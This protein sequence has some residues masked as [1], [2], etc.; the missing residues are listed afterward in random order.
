[1]STLAVVGAM[2]GAAQAVAMASWSPLALFAASEQGVWYD[3][4]DFS[5]MFQD[6]AGTIPVT[7]TGQSVGKILDKSGN[8]NH[9]TQATSGKRPVLQVDGSGKYYLDFDGSLSALSTSAIDISGTDKATVW[10]GL[11]KDSDAA[12]GVAVEF[13]TNSNSVAGSFAFLAPSGAA[14]DYAAI[15]RGSATTGYLIPSFAAASAN[16]L[17]C[18][19]A[20]SGAAR[21][22]EV[23]PR[24]DG[25]IPALTTTGTANAGTGNLG[26]LALYLGGRAGTGTYF[27]GRIYGLII[28]SGASSSDDML[29]AEAYLN[30]K[31]GVHGAYFLTPTQFTDS[32]TT[33]QR[34]EYIETSPFA[35]VDFT[36]TATQIGVTFTNDIRTEFTALTEIGI[37]VNGAYSTYLTHTTEGSVERWATLSAGSKTVSIVNGPQSKPVSGNPPIGTFVQGITANAEM[38]QTNLIPTNR[39]LVYGDS[40]SIGAFATR[41]T[42]DAWD[43][44]VRAAS[45]PDSV[46]VEGWGYRS[47]YDD[48]NTSGLRA[49]FVATMAAYAPAKIWLAIGTNDYG[50]D[51]WSAASFGTAY[52]AL[53]DDLHAALPSATIYCQTPI[54]RTT[55]TANGLGST[56]GDYRTQ[57]G[58]AQSTR[59]AYATL[60]DGT[61]FMTTASLGDG[62]HPTTAGHLLYSN[63][64]RAVLGI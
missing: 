43:L 9:A 46:A 24:A 63:S 42:Q 45:Y 34:T 33:A 11:R 15:L 10:C 23:F 58:T 51:K 32:G 7:T 29:N 56:L 6:D 12:A 36:T 52:A 27:N 47:L 37:W 61:A 20:I 39:L 25:C 2:V 54:L 19:F 22:T 50:L 3:P 41:P 14:S 26:N 21:S 57:I 30:A 49:A 59:S 64:V 53:L 17:A 38:T 60:V 13:G 40:I 18:S 8:N 31:S 5:T 16:V 48:A 35:S 62:V 1:M 4:S 44:L 28:R 55:E